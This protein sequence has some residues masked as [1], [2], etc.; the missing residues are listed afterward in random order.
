M[1][2]WVLLIL[3]LTGVLW[4]LLGKEKIKTS[5][6]RVTHH[7]ITGLEQLLQESVL[8]R[9]DLEKLLTEVTCVSQG[10][11]DKLM[12]AQSLVKPNDE[13]NIEVVDNPVFI[14][15]VQWMPLEEVSK[16]DPSVEKYEKPQTVE[17]VPPFL[18][19][20]DKPV[21]PSESDRSNTVV[22][23]YPEVVNQ[24]G[25]SALY[26]QVCTLADQGCSV[27]KIAEKLGIGQGEVRLVLNI[28]RKMWYKAV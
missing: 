10:I 16:N 4:G 7:E 18:I 28:Y 5:K 21:Q 11:V 14:S 26:D 20:K 17:L 25:R 22:L 24:G 12:E 9:E 2:I 1:V 27:L 8:V 3:G 15:P 6:Y 23:L 19:D 13:Q